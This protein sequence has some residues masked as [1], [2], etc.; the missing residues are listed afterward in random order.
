MNL[1]HVIFANGWGRLVEW[2]YSTDSTFLSSVCRQPR[3]CQ[4]EILGMQFPI[5]G[6]SNLGTFVMI[7]L[8]MFGIQSICNQLVNYKEFCFLF[9][10]TKD[11]Q[12][13]CLYK[14][15]KKGFVKGLRSFYHFK[16]IH[17]FL[18]HLSIFTKFQ[19]IATVLAAIDCQS[20]KITTRRVKFLLEIKH[21]PKLFNINTLFILVESPN[22]TL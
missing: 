3:R 9:I 13:F 12:C 1:E 15:P 6:N 17:Y 11:T 18:Q 2:L 8:I 7:Y 21:N 14:H 5:Y 20:H 10:L 4:P 22:S 19:M 16:I